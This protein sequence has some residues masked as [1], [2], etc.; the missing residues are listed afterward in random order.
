MNSNF[1]LFF[2]IMAVGAMMF[3]GCSDNE[4]ELPIENVS[5]VE[6]GNVKPAQKAESTQPTAILGSGGTMSALLSETFTNIVDASRARHVIVACSDL[7]AYKDDILLAYQKGAIITVTDPNAAILDAWCEANGMVY[8][9]DPTATDAYA[10][11]SFN[12]K[13]ASMSVQKG[14]KKDKIEEEDVPLVIFTGWLDKILTPNMMGPDYRSREI[15]KRFAPQHVSH[16]FSL[17]LSREV[18]EQ[19]NWAIPEDASLS[20]TAEFNCD[21]YPIHSFT[22]NASFS[23]DIYAVEAELI[24]HNGN[25]FNGKWQYNRGNNLYEVCGFY[26][27][28][29]SM[30]A[31]LMEKESGS[32]KKS[33]THQLMG[34]PT[35]ATTEVSSPY[36][37][38]LEWSFDGWIT[39][40]NGLESATPTPLQEGGWTWNNVQD[41]IAAEGL[42]ILN[43]SEGGKPSWE[44]R[45]SPLPSE[46]DMAISESATGDLTFHCTWIWGVP[47]AVDDSADRYYMS[48]NLIPSYLWHCSLMPQKKIETAIISAGGDSSHTFMIIPPSRVEGQ[49]VNM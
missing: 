8:A 41:P 46:R 4:E 6:G 30:N 28:E 33:T 32:L 25:L 40:G 18:L 37:S 48:V 5:F 3:S 1:R 20:T 39:G 47:Q 36:Q 24:I 21:I 29:C 27:S 44:L 23:G 43:S 12:K 31:N 49:R 26:L 13:A 17:E 45:I 22:D 38:G 14:K 35:P 2:G 34:G 15:K 16:V 19:T 9:G 42:D 7:D 10:L 11:V